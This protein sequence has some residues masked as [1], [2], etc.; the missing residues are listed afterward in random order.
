MKDLEMNVYEQH[1]ILICW[2]RY[3]GI[4]LLFESLT[5]MTLLSAV[6]T[7]LMC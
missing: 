7:V 3:A 2:Y 5:F 1:L 4:D 6:S